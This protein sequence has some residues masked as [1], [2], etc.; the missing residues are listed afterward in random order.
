MDGQSRPVFA[1]LRRTRMI[2]CVLRV[3]RKRKEWLKRFYFLSLFI[4]H[5]FCNDLGDL[6][7]ISRVSES[8]LLTPCKCLTIEETGKVRS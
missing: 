8:W 1:T 6:L 7:S 3:K 5:F 4:L 2:D